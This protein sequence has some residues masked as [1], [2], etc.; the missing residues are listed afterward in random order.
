[1]DKYFENL[2]QVLDT[3]DI[4]PK[5]IL[6]Q[7]ESRLSCVHKPNRILAQKGKEDLSSTTNGERGVTIVPPTE[8]IN[9]GAQAKSEGA[10][11]Y[12]KFYILQLIFYG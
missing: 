5:Q 8:Q 7:D 4:K 2:T 11:K 12:T 3:N 1:M 10:I 9:V 6:N